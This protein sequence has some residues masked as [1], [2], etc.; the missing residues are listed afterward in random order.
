MAPVFKLF[1]D[2]T[3]AQKVWEACWL[4][5]SPILHSLYLY[6][7]SWEAFSAPI[8]KVGSDLVIPCLSAV[9]DY[10]FLE[11]R[12]DTA[13]KHRSGSLWQSFFFE[14]VDSDVSWSTIFFITS[15][16]LAPGAGEEAKL[17]FGE[18]LLRCRGM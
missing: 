9:P 5:S 8:S 6:S 1:F 11:R 4:H 14:A 15:F 12:G 10:H 2:L 17:F 18:N 3:N 13:Q 16:G 7:Q